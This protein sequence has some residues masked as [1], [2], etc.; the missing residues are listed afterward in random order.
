RPRP[1]IPIKPE[2]SPPPRQGRN[3]P[4]GPP[5]TP[6]KPSRRALPTATAALSRPPEAA[7]RP[8]AAREGVGSLRGRP[9]RQ[10]GGETD[11]R[12][13]PRLIPAVMRGRG[14][15]GRR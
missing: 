2:I 8:R 1:R 11:L 3:H 7:P 10:S 15:G 6:A 4:N 9:E 14:G 13:V 5:A 12:A